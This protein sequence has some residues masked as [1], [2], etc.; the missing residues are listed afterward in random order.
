[1]EF[2]KEAVAEHLAKNKI[3]KLDLIGAIDGMMDFNSKLD[4]IAKDIRDKK[5]NAIAMEFVKVIGGMLKENGVF[6]KIEECRDESIEMN[7]AANKIKV[8]Y[9]V[10]IDGLDFS[11][12]DKVF[13]D[14]IEL[15]KNRIAEMEGEK[16]FLRM[17]C[18]EDAVD[19]FDRGSYG[20]LTIVGRRGQLEAEN[21]ELKQRIAEL[22]SEKAEK[23]TKI[24]LNDRVKVK[25][26]PLGAEI[27]YNRFKKLNE[28][29][30]K[31]VIEPHLPKVDTDGFT[32][33][34]LWDFMELYGK[35]IGMCKPNVIEPINI[36]LC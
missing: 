32:E 2:G 20:A 6:A 31:K 1:M 4:E 7:M 30:N 13:E 33:F 17:R 5:D 27:Y 14:K 34:T 8:K 22:E 25:L 24:N 11:E 18:M 23:P 29:C 12:H 26:T 19:A 16:K 10:R 15:L 35:H 3:P 21:E 36:E 28:T 9:G